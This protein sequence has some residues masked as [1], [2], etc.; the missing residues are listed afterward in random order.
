M[1]LYSLLSP[2]AVYASTLTVSVALST[3]SA[4]TPTD[5]IITFTLVNAI[6]A[7][8]YINIHFPSDTTL[9]AGINYTDV[10]VLVNGTN[11]TLIAYVAPPTNDDSISINGDTLLQVVPASTGSGYAAGSE[12]TVKIGTNATHGTTGDKQYVNGA[13]GTATYQVVS[14]NVSNQEIDSGSR[15][16]TISA[17]APEFSTIAYTFAMSGGAWMVFRKMKQISPANFS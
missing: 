13:A 12:M 5:I 4:N 8:G 11:R 17:A 14:R 1:M 6:A 16:V 3:T 2:F 7:D 9:Q 15:N 10:D